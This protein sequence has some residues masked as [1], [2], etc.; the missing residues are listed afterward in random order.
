MDDARNNASRTRKRKNISNYFVN[1]SDSD[2]CAKRKKTEVI[3]YAMSKEEMQELVVEAVTVNGLPL[4][5]FENTAISKFVAPIASKLGVSL[6]QRTVRS[7]TLEAAEKKRLELE[8][9]FAKRLVCVKLDLCTRR[10]R[11]FLGVN[12]QSAINGKLKVVTASVKEMTER[13][14]AEEIKSTLLACLDKIGIRE[15]QIYSLTTDNGSNVIK[16]GKLMQ[17]DAHVKEGNS[18]EML[19]DQEEISDEKVWEA[20]ENTLDEA[21]NG[22]KLAANTN[23]IASV[24][25]ALHTLQLCVHDVLKTDSVKPLLCKVRKIVNKTHT[26]NM[27]L[28]F[29]NN[30]VSLPKLDCETRWGSTYDMLDSV[31]EKKSFLNQIGLANESLLLLDEDW[32]KISDVT[33]ALKP[34]REATCALQLKNLTAGE[35]LAQWIK[36]KVILERSTAVTAPLFLQAMEKR[37]SSVLSNPAFLSAVYL[38]KRYNVLLT[39]KQNELSQIH[40][41]GLWKKIQMISSTLSVADSLS[42]KENSFANGGSD[43]EAD[44]D[45]DSVDIVEHL[46]RANDEKKAANTANKETEVAEHLKMFAKGSR[47][48]KSEC[49]FQWWHYQQESII[50]KLAEVAIALP[51]TQASVERTFSGLR[52]ILNDLRLGLK[53]DIVDAIMLLRCNT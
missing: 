1:T 36:C 29:K 24:R 53:E 34:L 7:L 9:E 13:A 42:A 49:I 46:L 40:L 17:N 27:R 45:S 32:E 47:I 28:I 4:S 20:A 33:E 48:S 15:R 51:V 8:S 50:K 12:V 2:S 39:E 52:Y 23:S 30:S 5:V 44:S 19:S 41:L 21:V 14:T 35:F 25:C 6:S 16:V 10:G 22:V 38:D 18:E 11:H 37:E 26:Q 31:A 3:E 43:G